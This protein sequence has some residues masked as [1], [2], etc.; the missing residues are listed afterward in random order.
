MDFFLKNPWQIL[1][2][3]LGGVWKV[4]PKSQKTQKKK[5]NNKTKLIPRKSGKNP[6]KWNLWKSF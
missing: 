3:E 2:M 1:K 6:W 4:S 5:K